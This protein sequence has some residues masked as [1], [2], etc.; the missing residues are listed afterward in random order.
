MTALRFIPQPCK[1]LLYDLCFRLGRRLKRDVSVRV[2]L[3]PF[4]LALK[5]ISGPNV[6]EAAAL[7][8]IGNSQGVRTPYLVDSVAST[9]KSY[10][11]TT[12]VAGPTLG[13]V[14]DDLSVA[15]KDAVVED[16]Q[17]QMDAMR[18]QTNSPSSHAISNVIGGP[19]GDN[20]IPWAAPQVYKSHREFAEQVWIGLKMPSIRNTLSPTI[21][22]LIERD[23]AVVFTH[24]DLLMKNL[25]I[26][27]SVEHWRVSGEPICIIDWE[28]AGWMP[29]YWESLKATWLECE[30]D[31]EWTGVIRRMFPECHA[32][33][34]ADWRWRSESNIVI[35]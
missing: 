20:R 2:C 23:V 8:L 1:C 14:W 18:R 35:L 16:L 19:I 27:S 30:K 32:E 3:L 13:D 24:G 7:R 21:R 31:T 26:P 5:V 15:D 33:L 17:R 10:L 28:T 4:G 9:D 34:D 11:L 6:N 12:W 22:S 25:I 29:L